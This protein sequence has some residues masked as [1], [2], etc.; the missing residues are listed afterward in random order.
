VKR[1]PIRAERRHDYGSTW[2][3]T[4]GEVENPAQAE[5]TKAFGFIDGDANC[6]GKACQRVAAL[7]KDYEFACS[8]F[9]TADERARVELLSST[10]T[11]R[12]AQPMTPCLEKVESWLDKGCGGNVAC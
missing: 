6:V 12:T 7:I 1:A 10:F 2:V 8:K 11:E 9:R 4:V 5:C 3:Y